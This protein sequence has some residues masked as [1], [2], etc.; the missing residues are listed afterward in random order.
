M[1]PIVTITFNPCVDKSISV[2]KLIPEKKLTCSL[3]KQEPGGGG[4]NVARAIVKLGGKA[5]AIYLSGGYH[6]N[7]ITRL[8]KEEGVPTDPI[9]IREEGRENWIVLEESTNHQFRFGM[10]GPAIRE[11]D[12]SGSQ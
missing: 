10:P 9:L 1:A 6:G 12:K 4:I 5:L 11:E 2:P 3:P 8:L 7:L